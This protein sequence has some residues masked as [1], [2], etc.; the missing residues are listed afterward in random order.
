[1]MKRDPEK[2]GKKEASPQSATGCPN[3]P[4]IGETV[5]LCVTG[6][7]F[8]V[9]N[10]KEEAFPRACRKQIAWLRLSG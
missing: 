8:E 4:K 2:R 3:V 9:T 1:M 6:A 10:R 7:A 5:E